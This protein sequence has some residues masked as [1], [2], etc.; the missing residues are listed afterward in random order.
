MDVLQ[1][2]A[3]LTFFKLLSPIAK[4]SRKEDVQLLRTKTGGGEY[5]RELLQLRCFITCFFFE[6]TPGALFGRLIGLKLSRRE[7]VK[8]LIQRIKYSWFSA[9]EV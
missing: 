5:R 9:A 2:Q 7:L 6:L 8:A 3:K 4:I 1:C